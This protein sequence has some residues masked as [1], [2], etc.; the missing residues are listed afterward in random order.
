MLWGLAKTLRPAVA[1]QYPEQR[2]PYLDTFRGRHRLTLSQ[3]DTA[4]CTA[5]PANCIYIEAGED[6]GN[7]IEKLPRVMK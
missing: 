5:C 7:P 6:P 4:N 1:V 2:A 3:D